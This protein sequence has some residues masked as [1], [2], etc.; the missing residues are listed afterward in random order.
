MSASGYSD[1]TG[2][3]TVNEAIVLTYTDIDD[4]RTISHSAY[5]NP[6]NDKLTI[7][8]ESGV[9]GCYTITIFWI[10]SI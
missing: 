5:P 7:T 9:S 10:V 3:V 1:A 8:G 4:A 2:T 6:F